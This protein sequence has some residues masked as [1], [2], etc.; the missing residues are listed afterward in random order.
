[1]MEWI[2]SAAF[3]LEGLVK[4]ELQALGLE[5]TMDQGGVRFFGGTDAAFRA[6][7]ELRTADR[8]QLIVARARPAALRSCSS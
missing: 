1:M 6:N 7:L 2:A 8:V 5:T 4:R 3:G